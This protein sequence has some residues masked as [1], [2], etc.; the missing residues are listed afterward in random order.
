VSRTNVYINA[1][2]K[3]LNVGV[4]EMVARWVGDMLRVFGLGEG[5]TSE[6]G[7][8]QEKQGEGDV[9]VCL[10]VRMFYCFVI[11]EWG[12]SYSGKRRSCPTYAPYRHSVTESDLWR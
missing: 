4:V 6:I 9:D 11:A 5:E 1:Q 8:G 7:W 3:N 2:G 10:S 12:L